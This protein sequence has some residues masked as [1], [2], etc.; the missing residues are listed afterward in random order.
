[1]EDTI[2][3]VCITGLIENVV[4]RYTTAA[5]AVKPQTTFCGAI[6]TKL[7]K[8]LIDLN[9]YHSSKLLHLD[10]I[11]PNKQQI[12]LVCRSLGSEM[13]KITKTMNY[14]VRRQFSPYKAHIMFEQ[15]CKFDCVPFISSILETADDDRQKFMEKV[16]KQFLVHYQA[17]EWHECF[18]IQLAVNTWCQNTG[19]FAFSTILN[20]C[21]LWF[22]T[23]DL[24]C[25]YLSSG[26]QNIKKYKLEYQ[27][28]KDDDLNFFS[29]GKDLE[30]VDKLK[31]LIE[32]YMSS[33]LQ[34]FL[35]WRLGIDLRL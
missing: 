23:Y 20:I 7:L 34:T 5:A 28:K 1:M 30:W 21:C 3:Y 9:L 26:I 16:G 6:P 35:S 18:S 8:S 17:K 12:N 29:Y 19:M 22:V 10:E 14:H 4:D 31:L 33:S 13:V 2:T 11:R 25:E 15:I 24:D 32:R 27:G